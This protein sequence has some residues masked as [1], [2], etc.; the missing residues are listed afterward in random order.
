MW[1]LT[2][3]AGNLQ[4]IYGFFKIYAKT[5][6]FLQNS[7]GGGMGFG[8]LCKGCLDTAV[9]LVARK[10]CMSMFLCMVHICAYLCNKLVVLHRAV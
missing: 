6:Y 7:L 4:S 2:I 5:Y 3:F 1:F 8:V 10:L 9:L